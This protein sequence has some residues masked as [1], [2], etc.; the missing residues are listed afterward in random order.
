[1][2]LGRFTYV[3]VEVGAE[4]HRIEQQEGASLSL[5]PLEKPQSLL[6]V[7]VAGRELL[8][9]E[10]LGTTIA[11]GARVA[12]NQSEVFVELRERAAVAANGDR[13]FQLGDRLRPVMSV[14]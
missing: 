8:R 4:A 10:Q 1:M 6:H 14:S 7:L 13:F 11:E 3:L 9:F 2:E 12:V 5:R